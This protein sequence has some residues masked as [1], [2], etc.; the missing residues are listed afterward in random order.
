M[1]VTS[2]ME[3]QGAHKYLALHNLYTSLLLWFSLTTH[4]QHAACLLHS[5]NVLDC[6]IFVLLMLQLKPMCV[7]IFLIALKV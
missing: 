7:R 5:D 1:L 3:A 4:A 6:W 2:I